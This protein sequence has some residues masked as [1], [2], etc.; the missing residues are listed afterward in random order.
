MINKSIKKYLN[1]HHAFHKKGQC[2]RLSAH[3]YKQYNM[4]SSEENDKSPGLR[5][6]SATNNSYCS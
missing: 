4:G 5:K 6:K 2:K 1:K 3:P